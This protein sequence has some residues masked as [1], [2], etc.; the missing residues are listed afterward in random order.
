MTPDVAPV[1]MAFAALL[2]LIALRMPVGVAMLTVGIAGYASASGVGPL[3]AYLKSGAFWRFASYDLAVIPMF[4]LMGQLAARSG[5]SASLFAAARAML[6]HRRGG[7]AMATIGACAAF[8]AIC[9]SSL[10]TAGTMSRVALPELR[11]QGYSGALA[12]G[13]LAAG[14]T[15][16]ILIPPSV[17]LVIYAVAVEANIVKLFEAALIPGVLAALGY[18]LVIAIY[19]R[20]MPGAG[21][22]CAPPAGGERLRTL[23]EAAPNAML[24]AIV[25]GG[26]YLGLF[27]PTQAAAVGVAGAALVA[28]WRGGIGRPELAECLLDVARTTGMIFVI[29]LGADLLNS[30]LALSGLPDQLAALAASLSLNPYFVLVAMILVYLVL[31][32]IMDSLAMIMLTVPIFWPIIGGLDFGLSVPELQTWFGIIVLMVAEMGLIT[33]PV[34]L[35]VLIVNANAPGVGLRESFNGVAPFLAS[36]LLRLAVL[37]AVPPLALFLPRL[38]G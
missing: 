34:G 33:P 36:D 24:F 8:G 13:T 9:G 7:L 6:G 17:V 3:L 32:C 22:A 10:A 38:L 23:V 11:R 35:N 29:L 25:I 2:V 28:W 27:D 18:V 26:I 20:V 19:V 4:L 37:V 31:G 12:T 14:G 16:G 15:L 1:W 21:A 5:M 30:Y